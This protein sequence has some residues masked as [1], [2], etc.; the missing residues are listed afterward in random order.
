[1]SQPVPRRMPSLA[2]PRRT[3]PLLVL[4]VACLAQAVIAL[5]PGYFS[6]DELQWGAAADVDGWAALPWFPWTDASM[7][8]WRPLTFNSWLLL[9]NALFETPRAMHALWVLMG[10]TIAAGLSWLLLRRGLSARIAATAGLLFALNPYAAYLHGW[11]ATLADL[12][13]V[14][15]SL[16]LA[17]V[18]E[19]AHR[20]GDAVP[21]AAWAFALT[22]LALLA[23]ESA[24]AMPA[25]VGLCWLL[26]GRGRVLGAATLGSGVAAA[27]YLAL[28]AGTLLSPAASSG[29]ALAPAAVPLNFAA[30]A[31][32]LP[33]P[34]PME[35]NSLWPRSAG[36]L[37]ASA[38]LMLG[39]AAGVLRAS[40]RLGLAMVLGAALT[41][42]P[43]LVL[44]HA[45]T[46]YGYGFSLWI[47]G[48][49]ALAWPRL[50]R[51]AR[52]LVL[53]LAA[54]VL[55][56]GARVQLQMRA[57]GERQA[58]F[59]PA[60]AQALAT[61]EGPLRLLRERE[62]GWAY[63][64]LT[65]HVPAWRGQVIGDRVAWVDDAAQ[66]DY[67]IAEDGRLVRP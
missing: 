27:A 14:G 61:H 12:L 37:V 45:A 58:V 56:H 54:L 26:C 21:A 62:F 1:M 16:A 23:K 2:L 25:L 31:M 17:M 34:G 7:L 3:V 66:A 6:H 18:L 28:R 4:L 30:Y 49:T 5:N 35:V 44:P 67:R 64:R 41:V 15:L 9:S 65:H 46:Q 47:V 53:V 8:Q 57:V 55:W 19:R 22:A 50:L 51:P 59:Q 20:R 32:Y 52:A 42:A 39:L 10:S 63:Q 36:Q 48:C 43:V 60:L 13:W 29:Y 40:P 33:I 24:L 38:L 11:V